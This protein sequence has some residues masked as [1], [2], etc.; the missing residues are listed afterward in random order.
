VIFVKGTGNAGSNC[1]RGGK[2]MLPNANDCPSGLAERLRNRSVP[3]LVPGELPRPIRFV[4]LWLPTM[5]WTLVPEASINKQGHAFAD[6][7]K[8][9]FAWKRVMPSPAGYSR[10]AQHECQ[11]DLSVLVSTGADCCHYFGSLRFSENV[12][13]EGVISHE[14]PERQRKISTKILGL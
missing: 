2:A 8:I 13:H 5:L 6:K 10:R 11:L 12:W 4:G 7:D 14:V 1:I 3:S 9:W